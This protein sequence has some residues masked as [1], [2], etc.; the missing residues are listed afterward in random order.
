M[1]QIRRTGA[2]DCNARFA[3]LSQTCTRTGTE[4]SV[5]EDAAFGLDPTFN[6]RSILFDATLSAAVADFYN[7]SQISSEVTAQGVPRA[8]FRRPAPGYGSEGYPVVFQVRCCMRFGRRIEAR[9]L[10]CK[11]NT[12]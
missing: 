4:T 9:T 5:A 7:T 10:N 12:T 11:C 1:H 3:A 8:F 2:A 6:A